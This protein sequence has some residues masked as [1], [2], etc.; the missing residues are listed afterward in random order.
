MGNIHI[1]CLLASLL[2]VAALC[3]AYGQTTVEFTPATDI[4]PEHTY[5]MYALYDDGTGT[6]SASFY[7]K[8]NQLSEDLGKDNL[9][10]KD[11]LYMRWFVR[12]SDDATYK[13][14]SNLTDWTITLDYERADLKEYGKAWLNVNYHGSKT[15]EGLSSASFTVPDGFSVTDNYQIICLLTTRNEDYQQEGYWNGSYFITKITEKSFEVAVIFNII[16]K[17]QAQA[18]FTAGDE[19]NATVH[20]KENIVESFDSPLTI[21]LYQDYNQLPTDVGNNMQN[22]YIRWYVADA[23]GNNVF[24]GNNITHNQSAT[25]YRNISVGM[26]YNSAI[27]EKKLGGQYNLDTN[28]IGIYLNGI[29]VSSLQSG[30]SVVCLIAGDVPEMAGDYVI[31]EPDFKLKYVY[32]YK[33]TEFVHYQGFSGRPLD[34][35]GRQQVHTWTYNVYVKPGESLDLKLPFVY[36]N[37]QEPAGYLRWYNYDTD[38]ASPNL[39]TYNNSTDLKHFPN[40]DGSRGLMVWNQNRNTENASSTTYNAPAGG[41][42]GE[43]IACDVSRYVD[44]LDESKK[45]LLH[46]PTLSMRYIFNV[47]PAEEIADAIKQAMLSGRENV[48]EDNGYITVGVKDGGSSANLRVELHDVKDYYFY[49]FEY[50]NKVVPEGDVQ[51]SYFGGELLQATSVRW[52]VYDISGKYGKELTQGSDENGRMMAVSLNN[53]S[54]Y[55]S[56]LDGSGASSSQNFTY[57]TGDIAYI[58]AYAADG[59]GHMCPIAKFTCRFSG[60]HPMTIDEMPEHRKVSYLDREYTKVAE[61]TFDNDCEG[62]SLAAPTNP[63]DNMTPTPSQWNRRHYG[64]VYPGLYSYYDQ[65]S[66]GYHGLSPGHGEYGLYKSIN[67][68]GVSASG[69]VGNY[70]FQ[71]WVSSELRDRTYALTDGAQSG[72]FLYVDASDE[73]RPIASVE[74]DGN[75]CV[76][77]SMVFSAAVVDMTNAGTKPQLMFKLYGVNT[78]SYGNILER[79]LIHSFASGDFSTVCNNLQSGK[80]YQV[81]SRITLQQHTDVEKYNK[82]LVSIDNY[83]NGT[84]GADYAVDDIRIY[85]SNARVET[86]QDRPVCAG[87]GSGVKLK[88]RIKHESLLALLNILQVWDERPVYYRICKA[89]GTVVEGIYGDGGNEGYGTVMVARDAYLDGGTTLKS[90]FEI[91]E[92]EV[93]AVL[94]DKDFGLT[95]GEQYYISVALPEDDGADGY[96]PGDWGVPADICSVYSDYFTMQRQELEVTD[97]DMNVNPDIIRPCNKTDTDVILNATLNATLRLPDPVNGGMIP[98]EGIKFDWFIGTMEEY[99]RDAK[100]ALEAFRQ[101]YPSDEVASYDQPTGGTYT[102]EH[103]AVLQGLV[104]AKKLYFATDRINGIF[105]ITPDQDVFNLCLVPVTTEYEVNGEKV[106]LC[107]DP[108]GMALRVRV[109]GPSLTL[110]FP[111]VTYLDETTRSLRV[112]L[113]QLGDIAGNSKTLRIPVHSF[114]NYRTTGNDGFHLG[115]HDGDEALTV[116]DTNDPTWS[117]GDMTLGKVTAVARDHVDLQLCKEAVARLHEGYWYELNF[118]FHD[119]VHTTTELKPGQTPCLGDAFFTMKT[120]PEYVTWTGAADNGNSNNWNNDANWTRSTKGELY[121]EDYHDYGTDGAFSALAQQQTYVP[122]KFT[123]VTVPAYVQAPYLARP[124]YYGNGII[125]Q[126]SLTNA[127]AFTPTDGIQLDMMVKVEDELSDKQVYDCEKFYANTCAQIYFKPE[128]ELRHQQYLDYGKAWVEKEL[129]PGKWSMVASPLKDVY[130]GDMYAPA[131]NGRQETEAF[132]D[133]R[134]DAA[135]GY[136]RTDYP[137]YQR[138]WDKAESMVIVADDDPYREDYDA[139]IDWKEWNGGEAGVIQTQWSHAYNQVDVKYWNGGLAGDGKPDGFTGFSIKPGREAADG[140]QAMIRLPKADTEYEYYSYTSDAAAGDKTSVD[141]A[142]NGK[143]L[144]DNTNAGENGEITQPLVNESSGN[145]LYMVGNPYVCSIDM[146]EFFNL[147]T[148]LAR[149]Y[150]TIENGEVKAYSDAAA[151]PTVSPMQSFF[152][153]KAEDGTAGIDEVVFITNM[154]TA[155]PTD[156]DGRSKTNAPVLKTLTGVRPEEPSMLSIVATVSGR[157]STAAVTI[158]D[159]ASEDF[160]DAEDVETIYDSNLADVPTIYTVAGTQAASVNALPEIRM[161]PIGLIGGDAMA[162]VKIKSTG[163]AGRGLQL[164]DVKTGKAEYI[165]DSLTVDMTSNEHGRYFITSGRINDNIADGCENSVTCYSPSDGLIVASSVHGLQRVDVYGLDGMAVKSITPEGAMSANVN[166]QS[167]IYIVR[168]TSTGHDKPKTFKLKVK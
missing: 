121:K 123:K 140:P 110:G 27:A 3:T 167:G 118:R 52:F 155:H 5:E 162:R 26:V 102:D 47:R 146:N 13:P 98:A 72:Y 151:L 129:Q 86:A 88:V 85:A 154:T 157:T 32:R 81:Y 46:E 111:D 148:G 147:N 6:V 107:L 158:D 143:L 91:F 30:Y 127:D 136:S 104:D 163:G 58:V 133:I 53:L 139:A 124:T 126:E 94:A 31:K 150:W 19:G 114:N 4:T 89:D 62:T 67:L 20:E 95:P 42:D 21:N 45:Y 97:D 51:E 165:D 159:C 9:L 122:M 40:G 54:G 55:F 105:P 152:V 77:S 135:N 11:S 64:F 109:D 106:T 144:L 29:S 66:A 115:I 113:G 131:G 65:A 78:D 73:A 75:L 100:A 168:V 44:G 56:P 149:K 101:A 7:G 16:T 71:W 2:S 8:L 68:S 90:G 108:V 43:V 70:K 25:D 23:E 1:K 35:K 87:D 17:E 83:C 138:S 99:E 38:A 69:G 79:K 34:E 125:Q 48:L 82:F 12:A 10:G 80:W 57:R 166:V 160:D 15:N 96:R 142:D 49:N 145:G 92:D 164:Y 130:A 41:W 117:G 112:G 84:M 93:Y 120:V 24:S 28:N 116:S 141:K 50:S 119:E 153:K 33:A 76:G 61:I 134:F 14:I 103:K 37:E 39:H 74:F 18:M 132:V 36:G 60:G 128:A 63:V 161:L 156:A 59:D 22:C 137:V